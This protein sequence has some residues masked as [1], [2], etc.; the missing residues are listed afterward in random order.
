MARPIPRILACHGLKIDQRG[1]F[2]TDCAGRTHD[3]ELETTLRPK[4][5]AADKRLCGMSVGEVRAS[6]RRKELY[7]VLRRN[8]RVFLI[9]DC[10]LTD[11]RA[12]AVRPAGHLF[13]TRSV[14]PAA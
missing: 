7:P 4:E 1:S 5:A 11:W 3:L 9:F 2:F 13:V 12:R 8:R 14:K 10:A 6:I